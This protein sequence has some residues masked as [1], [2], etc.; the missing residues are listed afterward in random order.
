M[1]REFK[2]GQEKMSKTT[3]RHY[4][5]KAVAQAVFSGFSRFTAALKL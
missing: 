2:S 3:W 5:G 4:L 1:V